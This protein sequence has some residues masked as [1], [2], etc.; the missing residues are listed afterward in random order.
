M[1]RGRTQQRARNERSPVPHLAKSCVD[2]NEIG[3][4][5][6]LTDRRRRKWDRIG[7]D[8]IGSDR[9][10]GETQWADRLGCAAPGPDRRTP[11]ATTRTWERA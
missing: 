5:T 4:D 9:S 3:R 7:S 1:R 11:A 10:V 6:C 8:R 2:L